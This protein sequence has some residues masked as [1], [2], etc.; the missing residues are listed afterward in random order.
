VRIVPSPVQLY[1]D[2]IQSLFLR[3][4]LIVSFKILRERIAD[5]EGFIEIDAI[6][7]N[8]Y[9]FTFFEYF[10]SISGVLKYRYQLLNEYNVNLVRWDN[11]PHHPEL[12]TYP[13]HIHLS[14][15]V[16]ESSVITIRSVLDQLPNFF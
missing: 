2:S 5:V 12:S 6:L 7:I 13:H 15:K 1:F 3:N 8:R 16:Q 11:A 10:S 9:R 14:N 4:P